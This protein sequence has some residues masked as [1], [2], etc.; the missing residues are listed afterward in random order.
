MN[1]FFS[2][3]YILTDK[4]FYNVSKKRDADMRKLS[5]IIIL[6]ASTVDSDI[7]LEELLLWAFR[8]PKELDTYTVDRV[9]DIAYNNYLWIQRNEIDFLI[10]DNYG[11]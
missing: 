3:F 11:K 1:N 6:F 5:E 4:I 9:I 2:K 7:K 8:E 10:V